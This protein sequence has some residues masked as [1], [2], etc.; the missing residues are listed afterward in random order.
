[1]SANRFSEIGSIDD[2]ASRTGLNSEQALDAWNEEIRV[3]RR[4]PEGREELFA[5]VDQR[6]SE[7]FSRAVSQD[8]LPPQLAERPGMLLFTN[9]YRKLIEIFTYYDDEGGISADARALSARQLEDGSFR[10]RPPKKD[11]IGVQTTWTRSSDGITPADSFKD[12]WD[13]KSSEK[14]ADQALA[15]L[16]QYLSATDIEVVSF[17]RL[18]GPN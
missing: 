9:N 11:A 2:L 6:V 15:N 3:L 7:L 8:L 18:H 1:M 14:Y 17:D 10:Q 4:L 16:A 12:A 13:P 5:W